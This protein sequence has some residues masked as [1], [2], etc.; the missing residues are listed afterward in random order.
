[1]QWQVS[2]CWTIDLRM[3]GIEKMEVSIKAEFDRSG[4]VTSAAI[5]ADKDKLRDPDYAK[6]AESARRAIFKC[7]PYKFP[8]SA[9]YEAWKTITFG[10]NPK[11]LGL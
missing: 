5:M 6:F 7:S 9:P 2:R 3:P 8:E 11:D 10:F 1:M 4:A